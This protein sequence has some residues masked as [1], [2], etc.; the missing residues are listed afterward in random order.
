MGIPRLDLGVAQMGDCRD[1]REAKPV[2]GRRSAARQPVEAAKDLVVLIGRNSR[3]T[4]L[5]GV[6]AAPPSPRNLIRILV[7]EGMCL[8]ASSP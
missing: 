6:I 1:Q 4:V 3:T 8:I 2:A 5:D 7:P